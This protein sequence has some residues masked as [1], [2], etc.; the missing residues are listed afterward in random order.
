MGQTTK[1]TCGGPVFGKLTAG[2]ER[3]DELL[4]GAQPIKPWGWRKKQSDAALIRAIRNH[5]CAASNCGS[6]CTHG[7]W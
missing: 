3:C 1:H 7:D 2:C 5:S 6:V 4:A